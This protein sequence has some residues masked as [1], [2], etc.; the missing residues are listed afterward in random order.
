MAKQPAIMDRPGGSSQEVI[1]RSLADLQPQRQDHIP[2]PKESTMSGADLLLMLRKSGTGEKQLG[3]GIRA[4][5]AKK[6]ASA[7]DI[8]AAIEEAGWEI[9]IRPYPGLVS[10]AVCK[11]NK[12]AGTLRKARRFMEGCTL[13]QFAAEARAADARQAGGI[14]IT[15]EDIRRA[16]LSEKEYLDF[17]TNQEEKNHD[18]VK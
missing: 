7:H 11:E 5:Q 12:F 17:L 9:Q 6:Q 8:Y 3:I 14:I 16:G 4:L 1:S 18:P 10:G 2:Q 15:E 13:A